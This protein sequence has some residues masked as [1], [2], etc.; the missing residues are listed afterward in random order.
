MSPRLE[1]IT[2][3]RLDKLEKLRNQAINPYPPRCQRSHTTAQALELFQSQEKAQA[4]AETLHL[5]GRIMSHRRMGRATFAD[6]RDGSGKIQVYFRQDNLGPDKY[7]LL[8]ELDIGDFIG[9]GGPLFRTHTGEVTL[10]CSE[11][12]L[13]AKSLEP[14]PEKW[15]GL[16]DAEKR[17]RQ[18]YLDLISNP[19]VKARFETRS[20][21]I[22]AM[23]RFLDQRGF[24]E[25]ET[26]VLLPVAAGA[27]ARP[28]KT[29]HHTLEQELYLRIATELYLKRLIIGGFDKVYEIGRIF[30]NEGISTHHNPEFTMLESYEAY[31]DYNAVMA[32]VEDMFCHIAREVSG[33]TKMPYAGKEIEFAPP[34]PRLS[35]REA[36]KSYSGIDFEDY[37]D[38]ESLRQKMRESG[39][40]VDEREGRGKLIDKLLSD[41]VEPRLFQPTFL[42]DYPVEMSPLAKR[43]PDDP[44]YVERFEAFVAGM[45]V[46]NSFTE[47]NDPLDQEA[48]FTE[49]E[50]LTKRV[51]QRSEELD[52]ER[53]DD[54]FLQAMRYGM[55]PTGGL[56]VGIDRLV[57][58]L[59]DQQSI[60]EVILFPQ[61][62]SKT[63][64]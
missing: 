11:F 2:Q 4:T 46:A 9:V 44:R 61:L 39:I 53:V 30:R 25:V 10:K 57:M 47:L 8:Q 38:E 21:I 27:T 28:F 22:S 63:E 29:Y 12:T 59:T 42:L 49:L 20:H 60:R 31:V 48:R 13:L 50:E 17:Y 7:N 32:M 56:G 26:P 55:P 18:R 33:Q 51:G 64:L 62:K 5:V 23:R 58:L 43:K 35:L 3:Q 34:W 41:F 15:H 1:K 40:A 24:V 54:D 19:E 14:L 6:I 36:V 16:V 45:E 37:P 52:L